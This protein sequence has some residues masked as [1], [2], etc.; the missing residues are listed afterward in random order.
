MNDSFLSKDSYLSDELLLREII[1][2]YE[3]FYS[4]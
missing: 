2:E 3:D 1:N 4:Y